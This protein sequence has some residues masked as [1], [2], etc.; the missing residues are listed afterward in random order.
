[1]AKEKSRF[2]TFLLYPE[3][4]PEDWEM[5]LEL[6]SVPMAISPLHD[7]DKAKTGGY[8]KPHYHVI[9]VAKNPVTADSVRVK[10][11]RALGDQSVALVQIIRTSIENTYLYLTHESKDAIEKQKHV[12]D[13]ADI[14]LLMNFDIERY[15][16]LDVE[17]KDYILD[18]VCNMID[19]QN[20]ANIKE[21]K[22][23]VREGGAEYG[24]TSMKIV[25]GVIRSHTGLVRLYFDAVYQERKYGS[26]VDFETGEILNEDN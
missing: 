7:K 24:I 11:K 21:L 17:E 20:L 23:F 14:K 25:N 9:Y 2:F 6:L 12:Y 5:K 18:T 8:K 3:S 10:I 4:I 16:T 26:G 1:M 15:I 19:E 13:K 22:R